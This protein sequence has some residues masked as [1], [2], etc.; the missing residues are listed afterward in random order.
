MK[1]PRGDDIDG[2]HFHSAAAHRC[3]RITYESGQMVHRRADRWG[4]INVHRSARTEKWPLY[5]YFEGS[6]GAKFCPPKL[7]F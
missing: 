2:D 4:H 5:R 1:D 6:V 7:S 3:Q